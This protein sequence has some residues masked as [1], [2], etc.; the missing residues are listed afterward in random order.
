MPNYCRSTLSLSGNKKD[1]KNFREKFEEDGKLL[2]TNVIPYPK[3]FELLDKK[4]NDE[5]ELTDE[6]EKELTLI[7]LEGKYD[8][9]KDGYN[10]GGYA[11]CCSNWGTK[12]GFC[13][14]CVEV[15]CDDFDLIYD[16]ET[17][18]SPIS[19]VIREMSRQFPNIIFN[20]FCDEESGAFR[21]D[22]EYKN[23]I[24]TDYYDR[25]CEIEEEQSQEEE[26]YK[27]EQEEDRRME[28]KMEKEN[29]K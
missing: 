5:K 7:G 3:D 11:W 8:M 20:Y 13:D 4:K 6:D 12:W 27:L 21:F 26:D 22:A 15:D 25:T 10:Q 1:I 24:E 29:C 23:G 2:A 9:N 28:E 14:C 19:K 16:F 18:W 17:A